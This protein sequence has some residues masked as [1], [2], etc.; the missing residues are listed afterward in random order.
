MALR[1]FAV[2][3]HPDDIEFNMAGTLILLAKAGC[4]IH[5]MNIADGSCGSVEHDAETIAEIR[6]GEARSATERIGAAFHP[7]LVHDIEIFYEKQLLAR[8]A[9]VFRAVAP[10][11]LLVP[12]P[13]DYMEDHMNACRLAV[14]AAFCRSMGNCPVDPPIEPVDRDVTIYHAQAHGNRDDLN[15]VVTPDFFV[16]VGPVI[17]EKSAMLAEHENQ[18]QWLDLSQGMD[19]YLNTM[20]D[21]A[22]ELG[23]MSGRFEYAEGW[24][25][26]NPLGLC[27][28]D[29]DPLAELLG[30]HIMESDS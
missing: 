7:P 17:E 2:A 16:D 3:A 20:R 4:E 22:R 13:R 18:K 24:R 30:D 28:P 23:G 8:M 19:A 5:C 21:F 15:R 27:S 1:V 25:R 29:A 26:H 11:I 10:D 14:T 9:S 6:T 12:S